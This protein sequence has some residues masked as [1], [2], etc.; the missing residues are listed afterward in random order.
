L[1]TRNAVPNEVLEQLAE[2]A[3]ISLAPTIGLLAEAHKRFFS[4]VRRIILMA[5]M[6]RA[7]LKAS[8]VTNLRNIE[9][10]SKALADELKAS[11]AKLPFP[12]VPT[13]T[14][15][16][17]EAVAVGAKSVERFA[18][19][20]TPAKRAAMIRK[21]FIEGLLDATAGAGGRLSLNRFEERNS[22]LIL[23][24]KLLKPYLPMD[25][26]P[27]FMTLRRIYD[28]WRKKERQKHQWLKNRRNRQKR[29][30]F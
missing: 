17:I 19:T 10:L 1:T 28:P 23:A 25:E 9:R 11:N 27:S 2:L 8:E 18:T 3:G 16:A 6:D 12:I 21:T 5:N 13:D 26:L 24:L 22:S 15:K 14:L 20:K 7:A 29:V 4:D 30:T